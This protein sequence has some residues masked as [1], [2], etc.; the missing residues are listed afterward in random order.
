M[1]EHLEE[2][3]PVVEEHVR[4]CP[5][6]SEV[7]EQAVRLLDR[8]HHSR[9]SAPPRPLVERALRRVLEE[10]G[11]AVPAGFERLTA[12]LTRGLREAVAA[13][14][15]DS[16]TPSHAV[17]SVSHA[18]PRTLLYETD[19]LTIT[20]S[21]REGAHRETTDILGQVAPKREDRLASG[22][23]VVLGCQSEVAEDTLSEL[24][25]FA[26][27]DVSRGTHLLALELG[28]DLV[29][30]GPIEDPEKTGPTGDG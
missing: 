11:T 3:R 24:G 17:R 26:F 12:F 29:R 8:L 14:V 20:V 4:G 23:R 19:R 28:D 5:A 1:I 27:R 25:E 16:W 6:C 15:S 18:S 2:P 21:F 9:L 10:A 7:L 22:G 30:I 13:L